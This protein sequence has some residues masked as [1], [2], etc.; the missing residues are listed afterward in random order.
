MD[1]R[2]SDID[3]KNLRSFENDQTRAHL[4][5]IRLR[6]GNIRGLSNFHIEFSYPLSA[7]A[8]KNG[9]GKSTVLALA[10]CAY[11]ARQKEWRLPGRKLPYYR[12]SDF[13]VQTKDE[14]PVEGVLIRYGVLH[15][16][17][18]PTE[19][20]PNGKGLA[21]QN[22]VKNKGG[23]WNDYAVRVKRPV[24][25]FG[26]ERVVP[27][28]EKSVLKNQRNYFSI[29][30]AKKSDIEDLAKGSVSR[31]LGVD[32]EDFEIRG[33]GAHKL[34]LVKR[35]GVNY[36]GFN[37]GAGE[38]ALFGLFY[39]MHSTSKST[40]FVI[41]EIELGL[42][43]AAQRA[44]VAELKKMAAE[45]SHQFI[46]TT[47]SPAVLDSL[48]PEGRFYLENT[49]AGTRVTQGI[50]SAFAS[51]LM[52]GRESE[53]LVIYVEDK[54]A[55]Q[56]VLACLNYEIRQ[57]ISVCEVGS[58]TA[59]VSQMAAKFTDRRREKTV[60]LAFLDGDQRAAAASHKTRFLGLVDQRH[61]AEARVWFDLRVD[62][63]PSDAMPERS[64][65]SLIRAKHMDSFCDAFGIENSIEAEAIVDK[66]LVRGEHSEVYSMSEDL[67]LSPDDVWRILCALSVR[68]SPE[69][70]STIREKVASL[71]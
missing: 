55:K 58:H 5:S 47:H 4:K 6:L 33:T 67:R 15:D 70:F 41:D 7:I 22:R 25:F 65:L 36:S 60:A 53:E 18:K 3:R 56:L 34:P 21:Y 48:P 8:G 49:S 62:F 40:L 19:Q 10:A 50:S 23:K 24:A 1:Y 12:F 16:N 37:M 20:L 71:L 59:V 27:P 54:N 31:V 39:A 14:V 45:F 69:V 17:W 42:H 9:S 57:R 32:Y 35:K 2:Y 46:F 13:F 29:P 28:S 61:L 64:V 66:A 30:A 44:L 68:E 11:H 51:G 63:L 26:I 43:E 38:Q 52:S